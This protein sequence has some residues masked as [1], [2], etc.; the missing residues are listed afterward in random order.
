M[1]NSVVRNITELG[2][3]VVA[4]YTRSY[5]LDIA[6]MKAEVTNAEEELLRKDAEFMY[7][8]K[9]QDSLVREDIIETM[10]VNM[11]VG[12]PS[13]RQKAAVDLG[14]IL[15]KSK[16]SKKEEEPKTIV[17]DKIILQGAE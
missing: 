5:D 11:R 17:P 1:D 6:M 16:F 7:Q 12:N 10:V 13:A 2:E 8:I 14:N 3:I 9:Y 15:Y 4:E